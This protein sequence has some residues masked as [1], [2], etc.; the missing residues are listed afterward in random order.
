MLDRGFRD[1]I[2]ILEEHGFI[3]KLPSCV[4]P[5]QK[6]LTCSQANQSR[7]VTKCR[8]VVEVINGHLKTCFRAFD[9]QIP[10]QCLPHFRSNR[11]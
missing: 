6:Q 7:L 3:P 5:T 9:K 11:P 8:Y 10:N 4:P 2:T 1:I